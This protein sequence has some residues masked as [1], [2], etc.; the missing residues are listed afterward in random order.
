LDGAETKK[1]IEHFLSL[2]GRA[3][4]DDS[5]DPVPLDEILD[6]PTDEVDWWISGRHGLMKRGQFR[7]LVAPMKDIVDRKLTIEPTGWRYRGKS[8]RRRSL[9]DDEAQERPHLQQPLPFSVRAHGLEDLGL[10][11]TR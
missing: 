1:T 9:F 7:S 11:R 2:C 10:S 5:G 3:R 6:M 4:W 8:R